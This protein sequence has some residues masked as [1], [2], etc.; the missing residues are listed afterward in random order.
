MDNSHK[1]I[2]WMPISAISLTSLVLIY[3]FIRG[4]KKIED[5]KELKNIVFFISCLILI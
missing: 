3:N 2:P 4:E 1:S 5:T